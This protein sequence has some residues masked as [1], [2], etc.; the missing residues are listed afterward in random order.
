MYPFILIIETNEQTRSIQIMPCLLFS[1]SLKINQCRLGLDCFQSHHQAWKISFAP[2]LGPIWIQVH[3]LRPCLNAIDVCWMHLNLYSIWLTIVKRKSERNVKNSCIFYRLVGSCCLAW[4][5][6][7]RLAKN[8]K[9]GIG[10]QTITSQ[11]L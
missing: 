1:S 9:K 8:H 3:R 5:L 10:V 11:I 2:H 6:E 7:T 4:Y